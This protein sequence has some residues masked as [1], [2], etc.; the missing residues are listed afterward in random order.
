MMT[1]T[2]GWGPLVP[3]REHRTERE[4]QPHPDESTHAGLHAATYDAVATA[5]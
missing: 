3:R 1:E 4:G 5:A 2:G